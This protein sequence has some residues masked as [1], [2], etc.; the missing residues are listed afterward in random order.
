MGDAKQLVMM[1]F[2]LPL[3]C[4]GYAAWLRQPN[5]YVLSVLL[6]PFWGLLAVEVSFS[7][8]F[9]WLTLVKEWTPCT[10]IFGPPGWGPTG[11]DAIWLWVVP[12]TLVTHVIGVICNGI[13]HYRR[14]KASEVY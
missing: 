2:A 10:A 12:T 6:I 14:W 8:Q 1:L 7:A 5:G 4:I 3:Y 13:V 11:N 9:V